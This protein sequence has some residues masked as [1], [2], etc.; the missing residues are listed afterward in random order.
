MIDKRPGDWSEWMV[1]SYGSLHSLN[2]G[3]EESIDSRASAVLQ[4]DGNPYMLQRRKQPL[5]FNLQQIKERN[6]GN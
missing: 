2:T 6:R 3:I 5:G 1:S 4:A